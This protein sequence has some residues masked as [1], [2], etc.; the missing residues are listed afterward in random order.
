MKDIFARR[1]RYWFP[2]LSLLG[3]LG[4]TGSQPPR[5]EI[6]PSRRI[7]P[8][9]S[10]TTE[11]AYRASRE[12]LGFAMPQAVD[13]DAAPSYQAHAYEEADVADV[14]DSDSVDVGDE[15]FD[16]DAGET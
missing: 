12:A 9:P 10:P 8:A 5:P 3:V 4:C 16:M 13:A 11:A 14:A 1:T 7:A 6:D 2:F 15:A